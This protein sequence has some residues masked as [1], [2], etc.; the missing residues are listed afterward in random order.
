MLENEEAIKLMV[1]KI[2]SKGEKD[3][4]KSTY[5]AAVPGFET[6]V[7][8]AV[9]HCCSMGKIGQ[10]LDNCVHQ[11]LKSIRN[12]SKEEFLKKLKNIR[13]TEKEM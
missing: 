12:I 3:A 4:L 5:N 6:E 1:N 11:Q 10:Q 8:N 7:G 2:A 9:E 13:K